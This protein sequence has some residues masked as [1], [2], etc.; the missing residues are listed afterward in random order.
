MRRGPYFSINA[1]VWLALIAAPLVLDA[2]LL[3][4]VSQFLTYGIFAMSLALIWGQCGL[5]CFGQAVFFGL[6]A[7]A[8]SLI[9]LGMIPGLEG[10][11]YSWVGLL[12]AMA[13]PALFANLLGRFLFYGRG[14][15]GAYLGIVT[16]AIAVVVE[17]LAVSW[18]YV[19]GLN[20]LINVPPITLGRIGEGVEIWDDLPVYAIALVMALLVYL[21]L[22]ALVRS[23]YGTVL[24]AIRDNETRTASFGYD[25]GAYKLSAFTL[26]AAVAGLAGAL[27]VTQ[28]SFVSPSVIGFALSTEVLIWVALGGRGWLLAAFLGAILLRFTENWLSESDLLGPWWLLAL[29]ALVVACVVIFPHG[30]IGSLLERAT[31]LGRSAA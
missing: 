31:R 1:A 27:F 5:L 26:G 30:V 20:G 8:M 9:T 11:A 18:P 3:A 25:T 14:L 12:F 28:F 29:G 24:R 4:Q 19:G 22:E 2:W 7:Y 23:P 15:H 6:G 13:V 16:L 21:A 17:R 10:L